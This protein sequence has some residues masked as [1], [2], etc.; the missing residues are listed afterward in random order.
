M[1]RLPTD[2]QTP[3]E[4]SRIVNCAELGAHA[5]REHI[6]ASPAERAAL[7][8]RF[9]L[10]GLNKLEAEVTV[11]R[12]AGAL[13]TVE[14]RF[15]AVYRQT[16][17]VT[18]EPIERA[19]TEPFTLLYSPRPHG[20]G[21]TGEIVLEA[22][23]DDWPEPI[24]ADRIDLGEAVAQQLGLTIDLYPRK[25]GAILPQPVEAADTAPVVGPTASIKS[26]MDKA[27]QEAGRRPAKKR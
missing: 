14:G 25:P 15:D 17:V 13:F 1:S 12:Q 5:H 20:G 16:C 10:D 26:L 2:D 3:P 8:E 19:V 21:N 7:A 23:A 6:V 18:L 24:F 27:F 9:A 22:E 4:L 11:S